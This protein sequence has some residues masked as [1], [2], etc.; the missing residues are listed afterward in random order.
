MEG[1][2]DI[3]PPVMVGLSSAQIQ[4]IWLAVLALLLAATVWFF[5]RKWQ[6][7][8]NAWP[9]DSISH[10]PVCPH[11]AAMKMLDELAA[12]MGRF[13]DK[14]KLSF[15]LGKA[16]KIYIG[17]R[18]QIRAEQMTSREL[19]MSL[20][21]TDMEKSLVRRVVDFQ[22]EFDVLRYA[23]LEAAG[24]SVAG[25]LERARLLIDEMEQDFQERLAAEQAAIQSDSSDT[26]NPG[27]GTP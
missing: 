26:A 7:R 16:V 9:S 17:N 19:A 11:A 25:A 2:H 10:A 24:E 27:E 12:E 21:S 5:I 8:K 1:L 20:K 4:A 22:E 3:R 13:P 23:P 14:K 18:Y 6:K 15:G